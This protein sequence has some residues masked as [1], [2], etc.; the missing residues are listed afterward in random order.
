MPGFVNHHVSR[1]TIVM[2]RSRK[3]AR[4]SPSSVLSRK[5]ARRN[6]VINSPRKKR[7]RSSTNAC[8]TEGLDNVRMQTE[9]SLAHGI[10]A[11]L[12]PP[13]SFQNA[14][15]EI[16]G[17]S[18]PSAEMGGDLIDVIESN[19]TL[20]AYVADVSGHGL[21]AGQLM[22]MLKTALRVSLQ[23]RQAPAALLESADRVLP[24]VK[25]SD[26]YATLALLQFDGSAQAEYA[27][28]GH[29][30]ILHYRNRS[31][32]TARLSMEQFPLGLIPGGC[33]AS[34]RVPYSSRDLFLMLTDGISEVPNDRDEEFGLARVEQL[35]TQHSAEPLP[36]IWERII[37]HVRQH[38]LQQDD[39]TLL[40]VR[41]RH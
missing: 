21:A 3:F 36:Q 22:G 27:L 33:Y 14:T 5:W 28:A 1:E 15:F 7:R 11:T 12:V 25:E 6:P 13:I 38:G 32:D 31:R 16:Y 23:F 8:T 39:Q 20:L 37:E 9:L 26:M 35:L 29:V 17:K 34:Q 4:L 2:C 18:M 40:L 41:V 10:Q 19:G 30:P 24:A